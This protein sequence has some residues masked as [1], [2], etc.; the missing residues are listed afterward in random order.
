MPGMAVCIVSIVELGSYFGAAGC[1]PGDPAKAVVRHRLYACICYF[2]GVG[3]SD[4]KSISTRK[5]LVRAGP[6]LQ[7]RRGAD[8]AEPD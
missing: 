2:I 5:V 8:E 6:R 4:D 7:R 1:C 3:V